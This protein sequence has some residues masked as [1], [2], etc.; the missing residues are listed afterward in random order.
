MSEVGF[1]DTEHQR[2]KASI[3]QTPICPDLRQGRG[4]APE[5]GGALGD[6]RAGEHLPNM[7]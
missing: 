4:F 1:T 6:K 3:G 7:A 5:M 2:P